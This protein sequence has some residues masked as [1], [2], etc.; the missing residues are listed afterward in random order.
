MATNTD[1]SVPDQAPIALSS[2]IDT[3]IANIY[4]LDR[5]LGD[6]LSLPYSFDEV[7]IKT[8]DLCTADVFNASLYK[9]YYNFLYINAQTKVAS[10]DFPQ[11]YKGYIASNAASTSAGVVWYTPS[12]SS[13][14]PQ[15]ELV[16]TNGTILSGLVDGA[17]AKS[18][19]VSNSYVGFVANSATLIAVESNY[20]DGIASVRLNTKYI[21]DATALTFSNIKSLA[22][23][24]AGNLFVCDDN[25][26]HK[27]DVDAV[28][29][30]NP[31]VSSV[32]RFLINTIGGPGITIH[33]KSKFGNPVSIRVGS[34]DNLYILDRKHQGYKIY[35]RDLN[36]IS[37]SLK[38]TDFASTTGSVVDM[39][40]DKSLDHVYVLDNTGIIFQY[41]SNNDL[42]QKHV[43]SD[44]L[45]TG[46]VYA[47]LRFSRVDN[48]ILYV[49]TNKSIFKKFKAKIAKSIGAFRLSDKNITGERLTFIDTLQH[50]SL[51]LYDFVFVGGER[52]FAGVDSDIGKILKF[53][54]RVS[55]QTIVYDTYK[56]GTYA[57]SSINIVGDEHV[58]SWVINKAIHKLLYNHLLFKDNLHSRYSGKYDF[59]GRIQYNGTRYIKDIDPNMF[60]YTVTLDNSV[61]LNEPVFAETVNRP[62]KALYDTQTKLVDM[63]RETYINKFPY[64]E[65]CVALT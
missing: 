12:N 25:H 33:D 9:L 64:P 15:A 24:T 35:D 42:V 58:T 59:I 40:I 19:G 27:F 47:K 39:D 56:A 30:D 52:S 63:C 55:Y 3:D 11:N 36:W 49:I 60:N 41:D 43:L 53:D 22:I 18:L 23:N 37:T 61:S 20:G 16:N 48:N 17:F 45:E 26:I 28:L 51:P 13:D 21:E 8:N 54:E 34:R 2:A 10:N 4:T 14:A 6:T 5:Y 38:S 62:L 44:V 1:L 50:P 7:K 65:Q 46:E 29:T 57:L 31:A 32:G